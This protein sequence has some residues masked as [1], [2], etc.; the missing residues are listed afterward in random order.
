M[1]LEREQ[2]QSSEQFLPLAK[3]DDDN[4]SHPKLVWWSR[5]DDRYQ[6]EVQRVGEGSENGYSGTL[7][8][9]DHLDNS[10][11]LLSEQVGLAYGAAFGP[12]IDDVS[13]WQERVISFIDN[14]LP[15]IN[16]GE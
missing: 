11:K 10:K 1:K 8:V 3:W 4:S 16:S 13:T 9:F 15:Q 6:I 7:V 14:E 12:D 5:L 2:N